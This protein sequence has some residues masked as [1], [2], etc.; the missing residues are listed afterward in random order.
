MDARTLLSGPDATGTTLRLISPD[1]SAADAQPINRELSLLAFNHRVLAL[2][3]DA[4]TPLLERLRFLCIVGNNLD[5]F[6]EIRVAGIKEQLRV[7]MPPARLTLQEARGLL[8]LIGS[9][10]RTLI[11]K[12]YRL[13]NEQVLPALAAA[14]VRLLRHADRTLAQRAWVTRCPTTVPRPQRRIAVWS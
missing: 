1:T 7:R 6:F 5:E 13:L 8:P 9:E 2:A 12:Q 4:D 14:G 11:D 10:V 3:S